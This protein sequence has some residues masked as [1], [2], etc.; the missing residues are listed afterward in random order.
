MSEKTVAFES[1]LGEL[2]AG[3]IE[4]KRAVGYKY[5]KGSSLLKQFDTLATREHLVKKK[6]PKELV[7]LWTEKRPY[8]APWL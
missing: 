5:I 8:G 6:L 4:E 3:Y 7:L 1:I 2:I